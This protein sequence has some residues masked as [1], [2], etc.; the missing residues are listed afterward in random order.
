MRLS[1]KHKLTILTTF[2]LIGIIAL[3]GFSYWKVSGLAGDLKYSVNTTLTMVRNLTLIDM[4]HDSTRSSVLL[5][6]NGLA[7]HD[8]E[9]MNAART[10][11]ANYK[12]NFHEYIEKIKPLELSSDLK[13]KIDNSE[14]EV[15]SYFQA[16]ESIFSINP[17][18]PPANLES[19][20]S[21]FEKQFEKLEADLEDLGT[22]AE[23]ESVDKSIMSLQAAE[24]SSTINIVIVLFVLISGA[25]ASFLL[26]RSIALPLNFVATNLST[27]ATDIES[28]ATELN[29]S[30]K[31]LSVSSSSQA[32]ALQETA[33]AIE[34][35]SAMI[36]KSASSASSSL[37][38]TE[39]SK[40]TAMKGQV[41]VQEMQE[42]MEQINLSN[43]QI[44]KEMNNSYK[45]IAEIVDMIREI[46]SKTKVINDIVFQTKLLSFNAS[47]ES[48]RA[49]EHGKGFSVV[50]E[51]VGNLA[52]V[53]GSAAQE[54][55]VLLNDSIKKVED[56]I[57]TTKSQVE[58][59]ITKA[60]TTVNR[61]T[62]IANECAGVLDVIAKQSTDVLQAVQSIAQ[63]NNEQAIGI[64]EITKA[65]SQLDQSNQV[66]LSSS[67]KCTQLA[68]E[69]FSQLN[70]LNQN[71]SSLEELVG[72]QTSLRT[73]TRIERGGEDGYENVNRAA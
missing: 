55:S 56:I 53:S 58:Q 39:S 35:I 67:E 59:M 71:T 33:S 4:I 62:K 69:L 73:T 36:K 14:T 72:A 52:T 65:M 22:V 44:L 18:S 29:T 60:E 45:N 66:N 21:T 19:L 12:N 46:S 28:V 8:S 26:Q 31:T 9:K 47:V 63:A 61:G 54:I 32:S 64:H 40:E 23:K 5:Y 30:S 13:R 15:N 70:N 2:L 34:E 20:V 49:G 68:D 51:E 50:A 16:A 41:V 10:D 11:L 42:S 1:V 57:S 24:K 17:S 3:G 6:L 48:A 43:G 27:S 7:S 38:V 37:S 25:V